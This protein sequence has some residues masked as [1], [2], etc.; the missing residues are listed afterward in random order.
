MKSFS[1]YAQKL[2]I[3]VAFKKQSEIVKKH[4]PKEINFQRVRMNRRRAKKT[5]NKIKELDNYKLPAIKNGF[6]LL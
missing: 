2:Q 5:D 6:I 3:K 1:S 4:E